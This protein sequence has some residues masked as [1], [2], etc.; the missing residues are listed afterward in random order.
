MNEQDVTVTTKHGRMPAFV[1][2]PDGAGPFPPVIFYMDAPGTRE[3]LRNMARRIAKAGYVCLLPDM[4]YRLGTV[5]FD[6]PRRDDAMSGV[7]RAAM[8]SLT[9]ALVT[10]D[11]GAMIA[12][13]DAKDRVRPGAIGCVGHC[14]SGC[15]I[16]TVAARF[17]H[18]IKAA[19]SL[20]GVN[21]VTDKPDSSHHLVGQVA[22]EL[23]YA[24]AEYDQSVPAH[25]IPDLRAVLAATD[26]SH[27]VK[28]FQGTNHGFCFSERAAYDSVASEQTWS[29]I[30]DMWGRR[31]G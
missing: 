15:Y 1:A 23:Y 17:P 13:L 11:T 30:F 31:L 12:W 20:Y 9:N 29:D 19:A 14:M 4:Y 22:G 25:V 5:R 6:I 27:T 10:E 2:S 8:N 16:T 21:I 7:I 3:E 18:R 24:F 26:V 28:V